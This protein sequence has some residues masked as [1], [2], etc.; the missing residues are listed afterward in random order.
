MYEQGLNY[1][2]YDNAAS[3][4]KNKAISGAF[5]SDNLGVTTLS[6]LIDATKIADGTV[7]STEFQYINTLSSNAQ[8]QIDTKATAGF[9]VAMAI[10]L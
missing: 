7:T 5:T 6:S 10:A 4:W 1:L 8:T 2:I 9:A 3:V